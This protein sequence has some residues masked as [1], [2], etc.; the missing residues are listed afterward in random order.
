MDFMQ[1]QMI[2][3]G[4]HGLHV[5]PEVL[6]MNNQKPG[7]HCKWAADIVQNQEVL[8]G[9]DRWM[10]S[11]DMRSLQVRSTDFIKSRNTDT[12]GLLPKDWGPF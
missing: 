8:T 10:S 7:G 9:E 4:E 1:S 6:Y 11:K 12:D 2:P 5:K 3:T